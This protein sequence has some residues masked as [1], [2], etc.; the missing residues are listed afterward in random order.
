MDEGYYGPRSITW[1]LT[2]EAVMLL[3]GPRALLLQLAHPLV[4]AGVNEHSTFREDPFKR[5]FRT[6]EMTLAIVFGS[7]REA[8]RAAQG[9]NKVHEH[10]RGVLPE[11]VGRFPA[12]TAYDARDP[13]LLL[14]VHSTLIDTTLQ[15]YPRYVS[16]L[17]GAEMERAYEESKVAAR[18]LMVPDQILPENLKRFREY[19]ADTVASDAIEVGDMQRELAVSV[20]NPPVPLVPQRVFG[21]GTAITIGLLPEKL[22]RG[23][24]LEMTPGRKRLFDWS[25]KVVRVMLPLMPRVARQMPQARKAYK[26]VAP[27]G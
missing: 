21:L 23:Y 13:E 26:R 12:G 6:L 16:A 8:D 18:L 10:V 14:W 5:L 24:R 17:S 22:R 27:G 9:I 2:R 4:A 7:R 19:M 11:A 3:G 1:R 15:V 20:L 25:P